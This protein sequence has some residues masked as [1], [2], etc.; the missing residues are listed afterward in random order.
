MRLF[1]SALNYF[2]PFRR[3]GAVGTGLIGCVA[4]AAS[5]KSPI[6]SIGRESRL[7]IC[8]IVKPQSSSAASELLSNGLSLVLCCHNHRDC[9]RTTVPK[10]REPMPPIGE[11]EVPSVIKTDVRHWNTAEAQAFNPRLRSV[12]AS[13]LKVVALFKPPR[14]I[15]L[16]Y[17]DPNDLIIAAPL[18][19]KRESCLQNCYHQRGYQLRRLLKASCLLQS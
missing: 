13:L 6:V 14:G 12:R 2:E 18:P 17:I 8:L 16:C 10:P 7:A 5:S 19:N 1:L 4:N 11:S 9:L 15:G 3:S